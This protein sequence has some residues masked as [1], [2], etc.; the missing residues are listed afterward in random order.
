MIIR[1]LGRRLH[2]WFIRTSTALPA[3]RRSHHIS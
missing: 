2:T 3:G 1:A